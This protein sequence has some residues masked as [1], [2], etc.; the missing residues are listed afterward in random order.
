VT[1]ALRWLSYV[2][3]FRGGPLPLMDI[4]GIDMIERDVEFMPTKVAYPK[5]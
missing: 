1:S 4:T 5:P 3:A 2:P